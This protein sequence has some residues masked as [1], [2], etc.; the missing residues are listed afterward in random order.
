MTV[1]TINEASLMQEVAQILLQQLS[2]DKVAR[3]W[4]NWQV[5]QGD[6]LDWRA[7]QFDGETVD[8]LYQTIVDFQNKP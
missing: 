7:E 2:P 4:A 1:Q 8:S 3:F 5:G 6:Y